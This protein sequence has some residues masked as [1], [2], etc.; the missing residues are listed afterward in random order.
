[1]SEIAFNKTVVLIISLVVLITLI[2]YFY[3]LYSSYK[4]SSEGFGNYTNESM[5]EVSL[6]M[7]CINKNIFSIQERIK[8]S[9][10]QNKKCDEFESAACSDIFIENSI[11]FYNCTAYCYKKSNTG[12]SKLMCLVKYNCRTD[13]VQP[14]EHC[15]VIVLSS[16]S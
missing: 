9:L 12:I 11:P 5:N 7:E 6:R 14:G 4:K 13:E 16:S 2:V 1:M 8:S 10:T 3:Y 15:T